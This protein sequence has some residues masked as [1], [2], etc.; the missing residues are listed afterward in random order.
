MYNSKKKP[1]H[2][3]IKEDLLEKI[4]SGFY[5]EGDK[6]PKEVELAKQYNVS[7]PTVRQAI[8]SLD[9]DGYVERIKRKGT[10]I[11]KRKIEQEFTHVIRSFDIE[12]EEKGMTPKTNV[13]IFEKIP[14]K[15][16]VAKNLSIREGEPVYKLVRLRYAENDPIVFVTTYI[17]VKFFPNLMEYDLT[18]TRLYQSFLESGRP[19]VRVKRKLEAIKADETTSE[20]LSVQENDPIFYFQTTSFSKDNE[21]IEYSISKYRSDLNSFEFE[22]DTF[23]N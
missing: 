1:L 20:L 7:R 3:K 4:E 8:S 18:K 9:D 6:I 15:Y 19:V 21:I 22:L 14:A 13:L 10:F 16:K 17:P 11:K 23:V 2:Q 12:I 5:K